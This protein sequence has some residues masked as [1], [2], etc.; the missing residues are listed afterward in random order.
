MQA[1]LTPI[2]Y[3]ETPY[4]SLAQ[5]PRNIEQRG[6]VCQLKVND[7]YQEGLT[8]LKA[9]QSIVILYWIETNK[10]FKCI[11][12][13]RKS[14]QSTGVFSLRS[15][16][17]PNPIGLAVLNIEEIKKGIVTVRGLDCLDGTP[18]IDIKP[19][20]LDELKSH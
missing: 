7:E 12:Q 14:K 10:P 13:S 15:P 2:G 20:I 1:E 19:A 6:P 17:R 16:N 5:C 9:G 3:I 18:L 11:Q 8:G 4:K